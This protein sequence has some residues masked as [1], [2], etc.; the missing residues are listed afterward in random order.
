MVYLQEIHLLA[1]CW[2]GH[3]PFFMIFEP[4]FP[5]LD[6]KNVLEKESCMIA[7]NEQR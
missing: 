3:G 6:S 7:A 2:L 5:V 4:T 1:T